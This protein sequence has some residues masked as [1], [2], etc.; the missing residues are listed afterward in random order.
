MDQTP[1]YV[2]MAEKALEIQALRD[3]GLN[4]AI[5][6]DCWL[7]RKNNEGNKVVWIGQEW[8]GGGCCDF[9]IHEWDESLVWLHRQDQLQAMVGHLY[10][11]TR[12]ML[13]N[14]ANDLAYGED[15]E[16]RKDW[17]PEALWLE[18]V[19]STLHGKR[20]TGEE[21]APC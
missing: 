16:A 14:M 7:V 10:S 15:A 4:A 19:M 5:D 20:W 13:I 9:D 1:E 3:H 21:W 2:K 17:S 18:Y 6:G 12:S 8:L 11:N